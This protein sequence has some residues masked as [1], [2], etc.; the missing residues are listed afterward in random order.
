[1]VTSVRK[2]AISERVEDGEFP[3]GETMIPTTEAGGVE[4]DQVALLVV[5]PVLRG[6]DGLEF[7]E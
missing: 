3:E 1:M 6:L 5:D 4:V 2:I 7:A